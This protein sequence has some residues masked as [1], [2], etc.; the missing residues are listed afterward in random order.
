[1]PTEI[2]SKSY[3]KLVKD[4][5]SLLIEGLLKAQAAVE[6][7]KIKIYW[8]SGRLISKHI[9]EENERADY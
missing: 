7:Q 2:L 8:Q 6:K 3:T 5:K 4:L 9:L 1:M